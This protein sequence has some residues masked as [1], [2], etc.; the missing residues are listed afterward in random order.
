MEKCV[1][2]Q[3]NQYLNDN[4]LFRRIPICLQRLS[5]STENGSIE[6]SKVDDSYVPLD[7]GVQSVWREICV[8]QEIELTCPPLE[9]ATRNKD[10][11]EQFWIVTDPKDSEVKE[12]IAYCGLNPNNCSTYSLKENIDK[13]IEVRTSLRGKIFVKQ[14]R[15]NDALSLNVFLFVLQ[16]SS[17]LSLFAGQDINL[18]EASGENE[19]SPKAV[20]DKWWSII[21]ADGEETSIVYCNATVC[22]DIS[23]PAYV[24]RMEMKKMS[25]ILKDVRMADKGL[26]MQCRIYQNDKIAPLLYNVVITNVSAIPTTD[27][28]DTRQDAPTTEKP[29]RVHNTNRNSDSVAS[30][31]SRSYD[32]TVFIFLIMLTSRSVF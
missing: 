8:E 17:G 27:S 11:R 24:L 22:S 14:L 23:C 19:I 30:A 2:V 1:A 12:F 32:V 26:R 5:H 18:S 15:K 13:R 20:R 16:F 7:N 4:C 6:N 25:L 28:N 3:L 10:Y 31:A 9:L 21:R 29:T